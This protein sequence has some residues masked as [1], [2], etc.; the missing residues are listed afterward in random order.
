[1]RLYLQFKSQDS[2][3][4]YPNKQKLPAPSFPVSLSQKQWL[5]LLDDSEIY[6]VVSKY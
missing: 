3:H 1:M 5:S 4:D 2:F 6:L